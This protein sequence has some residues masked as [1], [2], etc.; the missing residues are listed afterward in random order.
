MGRREFIADFG[1]IERFQRRLW[2]LYEGQ[3]ANSHRFRYGLLIL[4][5]TTL[6]F[7]VATSFAP[8]HWLIEAL[9]VIFGLIFLVDFC[10]RLFISRH[11]LRDLL[12]PLTW[13]DAAAIISFLAPL[14]G[15]AAGF[16]RILRT[17]RLLRS[18]QLLARLRADFKVF[19]R[20]EDIIIACANFAVFLFVTTGFV[21]ETQHAHNPGIQNYV[22]AL[23]FTVAALTT[24][25]FGDVTLPG[26][27]GRLMSIIIM[28][29][30][31][32][33]FF[34]LARAVLVPNK[35]RFRCPRCALLRHEPDAVHCKACGEVLNIPDDGLG[36]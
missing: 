32:T 8:R 35:V 24:T 12:N 4:D 11:R 27:L 31:V 28:I 36:F 13:A 19:R 2:E 9:D 10:A 29:F 34:G 17:L 33:L 30:G 3:D 23:Y 18:Y 6:A 22:D 1:G 16:L 21:Y 5:L 26:T 20:H 25:G 15:E 7:I 14:V